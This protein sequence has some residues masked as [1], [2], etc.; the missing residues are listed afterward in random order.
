MSSGYLLGMDESEAL[1]DIQHILSTG[2][3]TI[4]CLFEGPLSKTR[5]DFQTIFYAQNNYFILSK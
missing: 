5:H 1:F 4:M 3:G 2:T